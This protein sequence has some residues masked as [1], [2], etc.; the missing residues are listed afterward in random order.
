[1]LKITYLSL[2]SNKDRSSCKSLVFKIYILVKNKIKYF[3]IW[4]SATNF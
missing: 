4:I 1:M 2:L 3:K